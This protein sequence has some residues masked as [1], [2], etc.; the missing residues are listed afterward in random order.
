MSESLRYHEFEKFTRPQG[1]YIPSRD[2]EFY[3]VYGELVRNSKKKVNIFKPVKSVI[4]RGR[5]VGCDTE[6]FNTIL[7]RMRTLHFLMM[8]FP[9]QSP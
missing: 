9:F 1:P 6:Y 8:D 7:D 5:D 3:I 4:V 2:W